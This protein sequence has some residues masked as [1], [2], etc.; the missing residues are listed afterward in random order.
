MSTK[1]LL[2][3]L[4]GMCAGLLLTYAYLLRLERRTLAG[5]QLRGDRRWGPLWPLVDAL[6]ALGKRAP[7][8]LRG[9]ALASPLVGLALALGALALLPSGPDIRVAGFRLWAS[10]SACDPDLLTVTLLGLAPALGVWLTGALSAHEGLREAATGVAGRALAFTVAG[11]LPLAG[12]AL[13]TGQHTLT[14]LVRWQS[15]ALPLV[16]YQPLGLA[17][18]ALAA[19]LSSRRL[20]VGDEAPQPALLDYHLQHAGAGWALLHLTEYLGLLYSSAVIALVYLGGWGG[21]GARLGLRLIAVL[22]VL[23]A[24]LWLRR[25]W[26]RLWRPRIGARAWGLLLALGAANL[27]VTAIALLAG[28]AV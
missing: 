14:G 6:R 18:Y 4:L 13:V 28:G 3:Q 21:A 8:G 12:A 20:P 17:L 9:R 26:Y 16:A 1:R 22:A 24:L 10:F 2:L 7:G 25:T 15:D 19:M 11:L 27:L 23:L 5:L